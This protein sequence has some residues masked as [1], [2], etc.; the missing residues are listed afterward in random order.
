MV[1]GGHWTV[2]A[3]QDPSFLQT[4]GDK[5]LSKP[6]GIGITPICPASRSHTGQTHLHGE[7]DHPAP[8][9]LP[10][11]ISPSHHLPGW[12]SAG[13]R[14]LLTCQGSICNCVRPHCSTAAGGSRQLPARAGGIWV[15]LARHRDLLRQALGCGT[16]VWLKRMWG[17]TRRSFEGGCWGGRKPGGLGHGS[18]CVHVLTCTCVCV[19]VCRFWEPCPGGASLGG[20]AVTGH[21]RCQPGDEG[22]APR[23]LWTDHAG[24]WWRVCGDGRPT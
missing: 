23:G 9:S 5:T 12:G 19:C 22:S 13:I 1:G 15:R 2:P 7:Q 20:Q 8:A 6:H 10:G 3:Y 16:W 4:A 21:G 11:R 24:V 17:S 18:D 14:A